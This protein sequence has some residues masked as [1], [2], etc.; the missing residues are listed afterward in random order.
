M[1]KRVTVAFLVGMGLVTSSLIFPETALAAS[2]GENPSKENCDGRD[3][4]VEGCAE[5][6]RTVASVDVVDEGTIIGMLELRYS[7]KCKSNWAKT[8]RYGDQGLEYNVFAKVVRDVDGASYEERRPG[9]GAFTNMVY[10]PTD[11][12]HAEGEVCRS[13]LI[14]WERCIPAKT[15]SY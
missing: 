1:L 4:Q 15:L 2:C 7:P 13:H 5:D 8:T 12:A 9:R 10:A 6:G 14:F 11:T 3:P